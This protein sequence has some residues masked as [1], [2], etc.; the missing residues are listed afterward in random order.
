LRIT[1]DS[2]NPILPGSEHEEATLRE[3]KGFSRLC[4][5]VDTSWI[6]VKIFNI[7]AQTGTASASTIGEASTTLSL[8]Q[9][10][11]SFMPAM[12]KLSAEML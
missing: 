10:A 5:F 9:P 4:V 8:F 2:A 6:A 3:G 1:P 7:R 11:L 12:I